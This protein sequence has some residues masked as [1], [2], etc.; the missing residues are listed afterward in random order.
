MVLLEMRSSPSSAHTFKSHQMKVSCVK[1]SIPPHF[2]VTPTALPAPA[3]WTELKPTFGSVSFLPG[4][5]AKRWTHFRLC[6][7]PMDGPQY[8]WPSFPSFLTV[9]AS[10]HC[11][12]SPSHLNKCTILRLSAFFSFNSASKILLI[13][14][15]NLYL[16]LY[17]LVHQNL[18]YPP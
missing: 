17:F 5:S 2:V 6:M 18:C 9:S 14:F 10:H 11:S 15:L 16:L 4:I 12:V 13:L 1:M 7:L 3:H 8:C